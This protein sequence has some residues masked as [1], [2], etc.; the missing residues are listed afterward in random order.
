VNVI[1]IPDP[2]SRIQAGEEAAY[3]KA[4]LDEY[5]SGLDEISRKHPDLAVTHLEKVVK[6]V[7]DFY[8]AHFNLGLVYQDLSRGIDAEHE[9][10]K[11]S[12][13]NSESSRPLLALGRLLVEEADNAILSKAEAEVI[14]SR[15]AGAREILTQAVML[16][17]KI[18]SGFYYLGALDFRSEQYTIA[19]NELNNALEL[20][21]SL[22]PAQIML[23]N[24]YIRQKLWQKALD[25]ADA[26]LIDY[27]ASDHREEVQKVRIGLVRR[28]QPVQ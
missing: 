13:L 18:A 27:P 3:S 28:L 16:D 25:H 26:F 2:A 15:L 11:A 8:D 24:V 1:L 4:I 10:R 17:P 9:F 19:E 21:P 20:D 5:A 7:P 14:Q 23:I 22:F 12:E 6:E